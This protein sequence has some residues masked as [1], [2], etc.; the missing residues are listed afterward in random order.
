MSW[1]I[2]SSEFSWK[3]KEPLRT[4]REGG[5]LVSLL[6]PSYKQCQ[7]TCSL[8]EVSHLILKDGF[9]LAGKQFNDFK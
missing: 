3:S 8:L 1:S 2:S 6:S 5:C 9:H 4:E 7:S